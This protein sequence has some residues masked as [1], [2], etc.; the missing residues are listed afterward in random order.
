MAEEF[1]PIPVS[2]DEFVPMPVEESDQTV[3]GSVARGVGAGVVDIVQGV[4]E[5][6]GHRS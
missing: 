1:V 6:W 5:R 4:G 3:L 2:Q